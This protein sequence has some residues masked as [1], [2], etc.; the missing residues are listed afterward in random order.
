MPVDDASFFVR[1]EESKAQLAE[2]GLTANWLVETLLK[3]SP[4]FKH[5]L[6]DG[7]V[8]KVV[9][10]DISE[11]E[12]YASRVY[13]VTLKFT[14]ANAHEY[15][16]IMKVPTSAKLGKLQ[17]DLSEQM[18]DGVTDGMKEFWENG[19]VSH[20]HNVECAF[21]EAVVGVEGF[22]L[23]KVWYT[24]R[25]NKDGPGVILMEDLSAVGCKTGFM[26]AMTAQQ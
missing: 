24:R 6:G 11:G 15:A 23:P 17:E 20:A 16:V 5:A 2:S 25:T 19:D 13:K 22:P 21:Y 4:E 7:R 1:R 10:N 12:G 9:T 3:R 26:Q 18:K 14:N 8:E